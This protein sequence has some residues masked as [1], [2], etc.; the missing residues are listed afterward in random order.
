[1]SIL[2]NPD[3]YLPFAIRTYEDHPFY[4]RSTN[5]LR[6]YDY[7]SV[8]GIMAPRHFKVM[9]NNERIIT[10][11]LASNVAA[12][13]DVDTTFFDIPGVR[14]ELH[15]PLIDPAMTAYI[16]EKAATFLWAGRFNRTVDEWDAQ[17][18]YPDMPGVWVV[19]LPGVSL[20][21]QM[22]LETDTYVVVLDAP[23]DQDRSLME[24]IRINIGKPVT[25][26]WVRPDIPRFHTHGLFT[27]LLSS[28]LITI[29]TMLSVRDYSPRTGP[30]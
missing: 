27:N 10:D 25:Q 3:T 7:V 14:Q 6:V 13:I 4:G 20:Y 22:L 21:R 19:R 17:Q 30:R 16:G 5:D 1:M 8:S 26:V 24:W 11:F 29:T 28:P 2:L 18:P 12:N 23:T 9:Y 15:V